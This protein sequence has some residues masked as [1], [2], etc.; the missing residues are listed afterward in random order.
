[1]KE[2]SHLD[3]GGCSDGAAPVTFSHPRGWNCLTLQGVFCT[4]RVNVKNKTV[5]HITEKGGFSCS[6]C[7]MCHESDGRVCLCHSSSPWH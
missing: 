1:M 4:L 3:L 2:D 5:Q 7:T 6:C